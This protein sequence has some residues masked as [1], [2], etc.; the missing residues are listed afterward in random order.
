MMEAFS[1]APRV[2]L[3]D[4]NYILLSAALDAISAGILSGPLSRQVSP[5]LWWPEDRAWCVST[6]ID[7]CWTYVAGTDACIKDVFT[8]KR[9]EVFFTEP[10]HRG[11]Y[12]SDVIN[13]PRADY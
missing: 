11:D 12:S 8:D 7:F 10:E 6:E 2:Q 5:N 13:G 3:E 1:G 4:R 9:L